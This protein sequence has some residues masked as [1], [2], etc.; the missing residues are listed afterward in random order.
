[1][2]LVG[3]STKFDAGDTAHLRQRNA[4]VRARVC[5]GIVR[6]R[7]ATAAGTS[8]TFDPASAGSGSELSPSKSLTDFDIWALNSPCTET[9]LDKRQLVFFGH[10]T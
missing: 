2:P 9:A 3:D 8:N 4:R 10:P 6:Q 7:D 5:D 1:M